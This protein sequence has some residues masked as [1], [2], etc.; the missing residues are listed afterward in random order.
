M[1]VLLLALS[2]SA[3]GDVRASIVLHLDPDQASADIGTLAGILTDGKADGHV[4]TVAWAPEWYAW[5]EDAGCSIPSGTPCPTW[6]QNVLS[7]H[8]EAAHH[9]A[10]YGPVVWDGYT[11]ARVWTRD[12][13]GDG[14]EETY[15]RSTLFGDS[16]P[17]YVGT[18][19]DFVA[20]LGDVDPLGVWAGTTEIPPD[21]SVSVLGGTSPYVDH[22]ATG[23]L[24][25]TPCV[26]TAA[27]GANLWQV[28]ARGVSSGDVLAVEDEITLAVGDIGSSVGEQPVHMIVQ[29]HPDD[30]P[31]ASAAGVMDHMAS[32]GVFAVGVNDALLDYGDPETSAGRP[33]CP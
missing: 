17:V 18:M 9:H 27:S 31:R 24:V 25:S 13:D 16:D 12:A 15:S 5:T 33:S 11:D 21:A 26:A 28:T 29:W 23:D 3:G 32:L 14:V 30:I 20:D 19:A 2:A 22:S 10:L 8:S 1:I 7:W 6:R 4:L